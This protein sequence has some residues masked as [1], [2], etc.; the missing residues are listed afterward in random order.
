[1]RFLLEAAEVAPELDGRP[2][3]MQLVAD[4]LRGGRDAGLTDIDGRSVDELG[5]CV[6]VPVA[7]RAPRRVGRGRR[8]RLSRKSP[9]SLRGEA[10]QDCGEPHSEAIVVEGHRHPVE[11]CRQRP[12]CVLGENVAAQADMAA[13]APTAAVTQDDGAARCTGVPT[14]Q[15]C[16]HGKAIRQCTGY[17][18]GAGQIESDLLPGRC[19]KR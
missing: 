14:G 16:V 10:D 9:F 19:P 13:A 2:S 18:V 1:V 7:E 12:L 4:G 17:E 3:T 6:A 5:D 11:R 8:P 15:L